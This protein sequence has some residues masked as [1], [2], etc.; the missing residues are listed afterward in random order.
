MKGD[1][2]QILNTVENNSENSNATETQENS[3]RTIIVFPRKCIETENQFKKTPVTIKSYKSQPDF[4]QEIVTHQFK[5]QKEFNDMIEKE[6]VK[7]SEEL[8]KVN[9]KLNQRFSDG[10]KQIIE[11][12]TT[13]FLKEINSMQQEIQYIKNKVT[14]LLEENI[15]I[16]FHRK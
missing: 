7:I 14:N 1:G 10:L 13:S 3:N 5:S 8:T 12:L 15:K 9:K 4:K 6:Q 2:K 11:N 16:R